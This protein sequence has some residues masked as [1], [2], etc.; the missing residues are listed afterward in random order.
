MTDLP[1]PAAT[2]DT[3]RHE[4]VTANGLRLHLARRGSGELILFLH[5]FPEFWYAWKDQLEEFGRD[6][7][8]VAPDLRGHN[9]SEGPTALDGYRV[10]A[11]IEDV[12]ALAEQL[13]GGRPFVLVGHDWG[14]VIAWA[15]AIRHPELL[16]RLVIINAPHPA[17]FDRELDT[18]PAQQRASEYMNFFRSPQAEAGLS[19]DGHAALRR[20]FGSLRAKGRFTDDD[21]RAYVAAWSRPGSLTAGLNLYRAS[22]I[23]PPAAGQARD[24]VASGLDATTGIAVPTLVIWGEKDDALLTGNLVGLDR[25]VSQLTI[26]RIPEGT[27][28]VVHEF[29]GEVAARIRAFLRGR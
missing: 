18:N 15:F 7:L 14:G 16:R 25:Y 4:F 28:W 19:A 10:P 23:G 2:A 12:R 29:P 5:G 13:N 20:I 9:L 1:P 27:H 11:L 21:E 8:A 3:I 22:R 26:E 24:K 6:H 17:V